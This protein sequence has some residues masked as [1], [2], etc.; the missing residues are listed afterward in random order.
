MMTT[1][2]CALVVLLTLVVAGTF[3]PQLA[4]AEEQ[5]A[6]VAVSGK[7]TDGS[8]RPIEGA[9]IAAIGTDVSPVISDRQGKYK[10]YL[11]GQEG[12]FTLRA[13]KEGY[14][15]AESAPLTPLA[16]V[17]FDPVMKQGDAVSVE[18]EKFTTGVS[19]VGK[20]N[21]LSLD[22]VK[23]HKVLVYV[24]TNKW[25][26]HPYAENTEGKGYASIANDGSWHIQ[27]VNRRH[28]PFKLAMVVVA[29]EFFPLA[30][31]PV[32]DDPEQAIMAK[33]AAKLTAIKI[34]NAPKGL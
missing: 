33:F 18:M 34:V 3:A 17:K 29:R 22:E 25:Y 1:R 4:A 13:S 32:E 7:V 8:G 19:I 12:R 23:R 5:P 20:V 6:V 26:I 16:V 11:V 24:L 10:F 15:D 28:N 27:T 14:G 21:G 31:I 2:I 9:I 30:A